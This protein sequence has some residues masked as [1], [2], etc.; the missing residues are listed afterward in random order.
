MDGLAHLL[1][2]G[3]GVVMERSP[4]TDIVFLE[5]MYRNN[6][7]SKAVYKGLLEV[8]GNSIHELM[9][10]HLIIYLDV[11]VNKTLVS[12]WGGIFFPSDY[13]HFVG[14]IDDEETSE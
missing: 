4:Y 6:L 2:T 9:M 5:S 12:L 11:P 7:I 3:Q 1:S 8:R 14:R 13:K 10:P